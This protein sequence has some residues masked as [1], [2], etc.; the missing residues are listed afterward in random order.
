MKMEKMYVSRFLSKVYLQTAAIH[1]KMND[2]LK[3]RDLVD[4]NITLIFETLKNYR[5]FFFE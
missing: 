5:S 1:S 4:K 3:A 2:H